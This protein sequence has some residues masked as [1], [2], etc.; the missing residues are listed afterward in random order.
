MKPDR[1]LAETSLQTR[2]QMPS[3]VSS[4]GETSLE[5]GAFASG[6]ALATLQAVLDPKDLP[7][8]LLRER[9]ALSAAE[10]CVGFSNRS[11]RAGDLRDAVLFLRPGDL[12]GPAGAVYQSWRRA[13]ARPVSPKALQR[14]LPTYAPEQ[15]A[16]WLDMG[17]GAPVTRA[18]QVLEVVLTET[19]PAQTPGLILADAALS[20]ALGWR[21][22]LPL[23]S[24]G[25][26]RRDLR[27][28]GEELRLACHQAA[29]NS[30]TKALNLANDLDRAAARLRN[31]TP[32]LRAKGA[33]A[34]V[35]LFLSRDALP[36]AALTSLGSDRA[37]RR[38]CDR[39]VALGAAREL[40]G[41]ESFRL[42]GL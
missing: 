26:Q 34:A 28:S 17:Q 30:A 36:P 18:A 31:V 16:E 40:T 10:A 20:Q 21:H 8:D 41:R 38:F 11:E 33:V 22:I 42:Y 7:Q 13:V 9:L 2:P 24:V 5:E 14:A 15:I 19:A 37:A 12:P 29:A 1:S 32:K 39:L 25:L 27:L 23:L 3:W 35:E 4:R 6:A